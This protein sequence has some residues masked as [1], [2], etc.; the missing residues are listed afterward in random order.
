MCVS[1]CACL[2]VCVCACLC[3]KVCVRVCVCVCVYELTYSY[4][5]IYYTDINNIITIIYNNWSL[6]CIIF[7]ICV[8]L[9]PYTLISIVIYEYNYALAVNLN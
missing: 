7:N 1:V 5:H 9:I 3:I 8:P 6:I 2:S 4:N